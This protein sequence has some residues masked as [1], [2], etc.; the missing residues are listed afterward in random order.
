M[1]ER[2]KYLILLLFLLTP[3]YLSAEV[4]QETAVKKAYEPNP[5]DSDIIEVTASP[6]EGFCF[7]FFLFIPDK[8]DKSQKVRLLVETNNT[9][10]ATDDF[11]VH[12]QKALDLVKRSHPNRLARRLQIP[13]LVPAFPRPK[14]G[15]QAYTHSLDRDTLE[16]DEGPLKRLDLQLVAMIDHASALLRKEGFAVEGRIFMHGFSASAKFC[17]RFAFLHPKRVKAAAMGGVNGLPTLPIST[18][19]GHT[20]PFP[21]GIA[22]IEL[23]TGR[24]YDAEAHGGVAQYV[25]MG[26]LDRNDTLASRDAWSD[27]EADIIKAAL[28]EKMMPDRWEIAQAVYHDRLPRAQC[29]TYNGTGHEIKK[30]MIDDLVKFFRANSHDAYVAIEPHAYPFVERQE[31]REVHIVAIHDK[32]DEQ[33]PEFVRKNTGEG[34][35][36]LRVKEWIPTQNYKQLDEFVA[37]AGFNFR[38]R[39]EG[40]PD[41]LI[42]RAN[43]RGNIS[44]GNGEFQ[45]QCLVLSEDQLSSLAQ[46]VSYSL[47]PENESGDYVWI[48]EEGVTLTRP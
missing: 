16:I 46:G 44:M 29:V 13:L 35:F 23:F 5:S 15:W 48:V 33:L 24:P 14:T 47:H 34:V 36:L 31:L 45:A 12:R 21:I 9:G 19:N 43:W 17:N 42:T 25:Y 27:D 4:A 40:H 8:V 3:A 10:T 39:A 41:I 11:D 7:P 6:S 38:L 30:D 26:Y 28:A 20:L 22:D 37:K 18:R 2:S 32:G 1:S